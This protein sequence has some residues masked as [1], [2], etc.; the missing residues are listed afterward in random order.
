MKK[1]ALIF[2]ATGQAGYYMSIF[3]HNKGYEVAALPHR[4]CDITIPWMVKSVIKEFKPDEIYNFAALMHTPES[5]NDP[6]S[7]LQ[8]NGVAVA[9]ILDCCKGIKFF[10]AGSADIFEQGGH[11]RD[12]HSTK[13]PS[14]PYGVAK[15][16]AHN[17]VRLY[18]EEKDVFAVTGILFNMESPRRQESFFS[19]KVIKGIAAIKA[20]AQDKLILGNLSAE[21]DWGLVEEYVEAMWLMLQS[22]ARRDYVIGSG[23]SASCEEFVQYACDLVNISFEKN[24]EYE[25]DF[26]RM[27]CMRCDPSKIRK[28]LGWSAKSNYKDVIKTLIQAELHTTV[29]VR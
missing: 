4:A 10:Q 20:G 14:T 23:K 26:T 7:Y 2:G 9:N 16:L 18:R 6:I 17:L 27:D 15:L 19:S 3:L 8:V 29:E 12:E 1:K 28:D 25:M 22:D 5:W 11:T 13:K 21:R 24:V